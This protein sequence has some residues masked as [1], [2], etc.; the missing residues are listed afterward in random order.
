M[1]ESI[2]I[3]SPVCGQW[4]IFNPP[5]HP[6]LAYDFLAIGNGKS[7]YNGISLFR[8]VVST[9]SVHATFAWNQPVLAVMDGTVVAASDGMPDRL[10]IC[11]TKD[12]FRLMFFGPKLVPPFS[13]LG[14]NYVILKCGNVFPVYAHL[15][16]G[17]VSVRPGDTVRAGDVLGRVGNSGA[18]LQPHL[19]FQVMNTPD[20]FP[21]FKNLV[22]FVLASAQKRRNGVWQTAS[23]EALSNGDHLLL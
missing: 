16:N 23:H 22:P 20:P 7:P 10:Q 18:S 4:A 6:K 21:L 5:G 8:H 15:Q 9:I 14:G 1:N 3:H 13:A 17:S 11:M 19:H 2:A 12:L